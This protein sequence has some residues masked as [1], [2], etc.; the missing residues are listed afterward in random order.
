M[1]HTKD[2]S[3]MLL[4]QLDCFVETAITAHNSG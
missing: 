4:Q 1:L 3:R 2:V